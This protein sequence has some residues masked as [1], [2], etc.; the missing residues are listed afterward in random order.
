MA[1][2]KHMEYQTFGYLSILITR[3]ECQCMQTWRIIHD[4][5]IVY[6]QPKLELEKENGEEDYEEKKGKVEGYKKVSCALFSKDI[7]LGS[8]D[9]DM[10]VHASYITRTHMMKGEQPSCAQ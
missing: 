9:G 3:N 6:K 2:K 7:L 4:L 1:I 5:G 8:K 10:A